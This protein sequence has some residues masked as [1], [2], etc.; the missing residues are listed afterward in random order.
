MG[1]GLYFW[2]RHPPEPSKLPPKILT[3]TEELP[4]VHLDWDDPLPF[5]EGFL[6]DQSLSWQK[7]M[8]TAGKIMQKAGVAQI[9]FLH[10]TFV[11]SDPFQVLPPLQSLMPHMAKRWQKLIESGMRHTIDRLARDVGNFLPAYVQLYG[12]ALGGNIPCQIV[13]WSSANHHWGRLQGALRLIEELGL[14]F[15]EDPVGRVLLIGHSHARQVFALFTHLIAST[16]L[17]LKLWTLIDQEQLG[18]KD[19]ARRAARLAHASY[20]FVT[21]GAPLRYPFAP[22][23]EMQFLHIIN[24]RGTSDQAE[25]LLGFWRTTGG[26]YVQQWGTAG[27]DT[28]ATTSKERHINRQLDTLLGK[29]M[30]TRVWVHSVAARQRVGE[31]GQT[32]L[33]NFKDHDGLKPN[34]LGSIFGH[35]IYTRF[36]I[37]HFLT[38]QICFYLYKSLLEEE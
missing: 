13:N 20:D 32:L 25:H 37:M 38:R 12:E 9:Y 28:L 5:K 29:G 11:G 21:L 23:T 16:E 35:G 19:L 27:S 24:H 1:L 14:R 18:T 30:D 2:L 15:P 4:V 7:Q 36:R 17:G 33:V 10:G 26:D 22:S 34:G 6:K 8:R 31:L 3:K